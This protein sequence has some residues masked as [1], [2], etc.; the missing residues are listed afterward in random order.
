MTATSLRYL[1]EQHELKFVK[2]L[3]QKS[4]QTRMYYRSGTEISSYIGQVHSRHLVPTDQ[5]AA[6]FYMK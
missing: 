4:K 3:F 6:L 1:K 2:L 5:V